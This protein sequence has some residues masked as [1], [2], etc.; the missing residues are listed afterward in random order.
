MQI[1]VG[2]EESQ[3]VTIALR[4]LGH[5]AY[6]CDLQDCS[7]GHPEW[8]L[9]MDV[10]Q[11]I[12]LKR[13]DMGIFFPDYTYLAVSGLHWNKRKPGRAE[14]TEKALQHVC[15]L[16]NC[17]IPKIAVENPVGCI[18][19]RIHLVNGVYMVSDTPVNGRKPN[20][21]IQPYQFGHNASKKT[22]L[23]LTNL[24]LLEATTYYKPRIVNGRE[25]W[26]NQ[27][28][29]GQNNLPPSAERAKLRSKTYKGVAEAMAMQWAKPADHFKN[30]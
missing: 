27:T 17:G 4:G 22:C 1:L 10:M 14:K 5:E 6:S 18:S 12:K 26:D 9:K 30:L 28:D 13:W 23:W 11:A 2:H 15:D 8:H 7:G 24:P 19:T 3:E 21:I 20:Q 16:F 29:S 25:R